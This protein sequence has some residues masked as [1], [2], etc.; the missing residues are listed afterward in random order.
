[1]SSPGILDTDRHRDTPEGVT[2]ALPVAGPAVRFFAWFLDTMV[3]LLAY[4]ALASILGLLGDLGVGLSLLVLFLLL[5]FYPVFFEVRRN[6]ITPGKKSLGLQ[7]IH[8]DGTP[9]ELTAS[10]LR[11]LLL[12]AD[13]LPF[14]YGAGL[15]SMLVD[16][17]FRRLGDI[18]AGTLVVHRERP[19]QVGEVPAEIPLAPPVALRRD[20][21]RAV[22]SFASRVTTWSGERAA[23]LAN[24]ARPLTGSRGTEGV[25]RLVGMANWILGRNA[26]AR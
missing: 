20:E 21:R 9:V 7:V 11:N 15:V 18:A 6:G 4:A 19:Q 17:D 22:V 10:L 1:M 25:R 26:E 8:A 16:R 2:L 14:F 23:E 3:V 12:A 5:W 24:L 13:F